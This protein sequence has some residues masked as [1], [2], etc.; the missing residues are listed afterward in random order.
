MKLLPLITLAAVPLAQVAS[1][2]FFIYKIRE[3]IPIPDAG[4]PFHV[5]IFSKGHIS[6]QE[7]IYGD[8]TV[9][10]DDVS[11]DKR[12]VSCDGSGCFFGD[13]H[14]IDRLEVNNALGHFSK[15]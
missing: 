5:Y 3:H 13:P 15:S 12:G 8:S 1:A 4:G 6:C 10:R 11:G 2:N 9:E 14:D 7:V